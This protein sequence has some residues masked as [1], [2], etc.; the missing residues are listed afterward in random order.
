MGSLLK[1][2]WLKARTRPMHRVLLVLLASTGLLFSLFVA[3]NSMA[4]PAMRQHAREV[5]PWPHILE[6]SL[7]MSQV[8]GRLTVII[9]TASIVGGEYGYDTWKMLLPRRPGR[10]EFLAAKLGMSLIAMA[11]GLAAVVASFVVPGLVAARL[12]GLEPVGGVNVGVV[13]WRFACFFLEASFYVAATLL[14]SVL[15]RSTFGGILLGSALMLTLDLVGRAHPWLALVLPDMHLQNLQALLSGDS[16]LLDRV[17]M[18]FEREVSL[19]TSAAVWAL[20]VAAFLGAAF[21]LFRRRDLAG[22][23]GG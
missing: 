5:L 22:G 2:E 19:A 4:D 12:L 18:T 21:A 11:L 16:D 20:Y 10:G 6:Q 23:S 15:T 14:A 9:L 13:G 1:A 3:L 8:F 7:K 17:Q